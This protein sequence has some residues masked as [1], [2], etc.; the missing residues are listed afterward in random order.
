LS[1]GV[2]T[3][4]IISGVL[5]AVAV[6][7]CVMTRQSPLAAALAGFGF[8]VGLPRWALGFLR[9]RRQKKFTREFA[10]GIDIIVRSVRSGLPTNEALKIVAKE[11]PE[12]VSGE[13]HK[14]VE[15][16]K[17]GVTLEQA[18]KRMYDA[19]PTAEVAF[20]GIVMTIQAKSGGNLS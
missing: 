7:V 13:F 3:F 5:A 8:G 20:F 18:L 15:G 4:W 9:N 6:L 16:L 1:I 14:L 17:V 10:N 12:P 19:M 2:Q 11:L